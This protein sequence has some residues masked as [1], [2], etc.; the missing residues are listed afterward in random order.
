MNDLV[1]PDLKAEALRLHGLAE[2][3]ARKAVDVAWEAGAAFL[4]VKSSLKH[5]EYEAWLISEG[6]KP[7]SI[8]SYTKLVLDYPEKGE[9]FTF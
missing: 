3:L 7:N 4:R 6:L 2:S 5:G 9:S 8:R 1:I